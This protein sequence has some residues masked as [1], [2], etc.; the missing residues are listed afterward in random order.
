M[1][2]LDQLPNART[3]AKSVPAFYRKK[4]ERTLMSLAEEI[5]EDKRII[6]LIHPAIVSVAAGVCGS[7]VMRNKERCC[8]EDVCHDSVQ[9]SNVLIAP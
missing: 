9:K 5:G 6:D 7:R 4:A 8:S 3:E 1:E 2:L